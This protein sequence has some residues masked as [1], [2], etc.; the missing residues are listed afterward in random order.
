MARLRIFAPSVF[1][2]FSSLLE[3][4]WLKSGSVVSIAELQ[5]MQVFALMK[6]TTLQFGHFLFIN[7]NGGFAAPL[8]FI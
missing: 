6:L 3:T 2:C 8:T 7:K 4:F 5:R 1:G